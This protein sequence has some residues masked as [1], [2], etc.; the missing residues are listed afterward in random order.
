LASVILGIAHNSWKQMV[1]DRI[2]YL[3]L[4]VACL[5]LGFSYL[6]AMLTIVESRKILLD[7][8]FSAVSVASGLIAIYL[9]IVSVAKELDQRIIYCVVSKPISRAVYLVGKFLG[10]TLVLL[11][12]HALLSV[13]LLGILLVMDEP[14]PQ[15]MAA[16]F[17]LIFLET[18]ILLALAF[19]F[20]TFSSTMLASGLAIAFF[21][22]GRSNSSFLTLKDKAHSEE[23]KALA[24]FI[25]Y[26]SPNLER[27]NIRDVV[28]YGRPFPTEMLWVGPLYAGAF[29]LVCLS[30][31][32][33]IIRQR[34]LP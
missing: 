20:S 1:R 6:L 4:L 27:F 29:L 28:A 14:I 11:A 33:L 15:G 31:S 10:A 26:L 21:L 7:F 9:G 8:G 12:V 17:F 30:A 5:M 23:A 19:F 2:F 22:I 13:N 32:V 25:Y 16:C 34:D 24:R 3:V 18:M